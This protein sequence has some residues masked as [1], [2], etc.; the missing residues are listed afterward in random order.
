LM[1]GLPKMATS[2]FNEQVAL[3]VLLEAK[4][5]PNKVVIVDVP[6]I[7]LTVVVCAEEV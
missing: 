3:H 6:R 5:D 1:Y 4:A 7:A 2:R